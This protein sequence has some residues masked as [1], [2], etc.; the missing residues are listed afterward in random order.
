MKVLYQIFKTALAV[1]FIGL[2]AI[3]CEKSA[4]LSI[5]P[6]VIEAPFTFTPTHGSAGTAVTI[7]GSGLNDVQKVSFL[8]LIHI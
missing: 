2:V 5:D 1:V 6:I 4:P 8:S 7:A 3:S